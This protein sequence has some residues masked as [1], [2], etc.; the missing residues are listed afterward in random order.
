MCNGL[1]QMWINVYLKYNNF[2]WVAY[3]HGRNS[4]VF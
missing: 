1:I 4:Y 3:F 2:I